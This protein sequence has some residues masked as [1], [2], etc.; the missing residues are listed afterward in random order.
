M[1]CAREKIVGLEL[2]DLVLLNECGNITGLRDGIT[3]EVDDGFWTDFE[4]FF[5]KLSV[6]AGARR[7]ENYGTIWGDI[8]GN[9]FG[10]GE[11]AF[12]VGVF[13][14]LLHFGKGGAINFDKCEVFVA[15]DGK[16]DAAY[17]GVKV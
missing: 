10:F 6:T 11:D 8:I 15:S 3:T 1:G 7:V 17:A 9:V 16:T 13:G 14:V 12:S 5:D 2:F 4:E